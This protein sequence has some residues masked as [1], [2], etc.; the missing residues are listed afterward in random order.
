MTT[1]KTALYRHYDKDDVLLYI[2]I[3]LSA[4]ARLKQHQSS[5]RWFYDTAIMTIEWFDSVEQAREE[6]LCAIKNESPI[7]NVVHNTNT[8]IHCPFCNG[9]A[10]ISYEGDKHWMVGCL[11]A[12]DECEVA[13]FVM[14]DNKDKA[15]IAWNSRQERQK[16]AC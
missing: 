2:G 11:R 4:V 8:L 13:P 10:S 16:S 14:S 5:S 7:Y 12:A 1:K 6:E 9:F 15:V 3:S